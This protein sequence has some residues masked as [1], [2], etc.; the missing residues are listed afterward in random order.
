MC[1]TINPLETDRGPHCGADHDHVLS[2][3]LGLTFKCN[4]MIGKPLKWQQF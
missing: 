1:Q 4:I 3:F 2:Q